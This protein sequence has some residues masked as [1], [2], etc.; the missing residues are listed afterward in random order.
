MTENDMFEL[1][2]EEIIK[3]LDGLYM[4]T[5]EEEVYRSGQKSGFLYAIKVYREHKDG[6]WIK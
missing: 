4:D 5:Q 3:F 6:G 2:I 1:R